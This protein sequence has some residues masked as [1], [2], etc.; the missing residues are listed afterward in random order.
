VAKLLASDGYNYTIFG[1]S[2]A[3]SG[4]T[5]VVGAPEP[6]RRSAYVFERDGSGNWVEVAK[7]PPSGGFDYDQWGRS[8]AV[9]G[10]TIVVGGFDGDCRGHGCLFGS[11]EVFE[12]DGVG[13]WAQ[14]AK[15]LASD[16]AAS[17][18]FGSSVAVSGDTVMVGIGPGHSA[19]A[20]GF[21]RVWLDLNPQISVTGT[22]PGQVTLTATGG[23]P[24][25]RGR[26]A[27]AFALGLTPLPPQ[28]VCAGTNLDLQ[29]AFQLLGTGRLNFTG[30]GNWTRTATVSH[31][32]LMLQAVD[33][34]TCELTNIVT[35]P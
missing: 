26:L 13:A 29:N 19:S 10:N 25:G 20:Y 28:D 22:C 6:P 32:G 2:V 27:G 7:L 23:A 12:R 18:G 3:I 31:C 11:A 30:A 1:W 21:E 24:Y 8:V 34:I 33:D 9:S 15:L 16:L 35:M 14:A 5:V 17:D 4:D